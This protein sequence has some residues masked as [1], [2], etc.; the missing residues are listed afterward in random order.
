MMVVELYTYIEDA[1]TPPKLTAVAPV[2]FNP[3]I[4]TDCPAEVEVGLKA[5]ITGCPT[6]FLKTDTVLSLPLSSAISGFPSPS[7]S[8]TAQ[9]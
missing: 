1:A 8:P 7:K 4:I 3:D 2:K 5:V 9:P 6:W